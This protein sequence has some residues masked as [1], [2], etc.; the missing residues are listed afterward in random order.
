MLTVTEARAIRPRVQAQLVQTFGKGD[1]NNVGRCPHFLERFYLI[2]PF[3]LR[4][5]DKDTDL[6][7]RLE[8]HFTQT[9]RLS[10]ELGEEL[11]AK[12]LAV[13]VFGPEGKPIFYSL[14]GT[15]RPEQ[16][17]LA[18]MQAEI[19]SN[20]TIADVSVFTKG[21]YGIELE[22]QS[23]RFDFPAGAIPAGNLDQLLDPRRKIGANLAAQGIKRIIILPFTAHPYK[24]EQTG[25][26]LSVP[27]ILLDGDSVMLDVLLQL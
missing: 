4:K 26:T 7:S 2:T 9:D 5:L 6:L 27:V 20:P 3:A 18:E 11:Q 16:A 19:A 17:L 13:T 22:D 8:R 15:N 10:R 24:V 1:N 23:K 14:S 21:L 12:G 25:D